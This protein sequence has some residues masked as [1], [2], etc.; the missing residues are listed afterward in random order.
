MSASTSVGLKIA[1]RS[2]K[3]RKFAPEDV[4]DKGLGYVQEDD[5]IDDTEA[6]TKIPFPYY[7]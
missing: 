7:L 4:M 1:K 2:K 3:V 5:F 6:V